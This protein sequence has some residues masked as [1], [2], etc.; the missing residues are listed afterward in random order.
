MGARREADSR[1]AGN[2]R[3]SAA[4]TRRRGS[5]KTGRGDEAFAERLETILGEITG[6]LEG[7]DPEQARDFARA[8]LKAKRIYVAGVGRSGLVSA[9]FAMRLVHLGLVAHVVGEVTA[10]GLG[11]GDLLVISSGSGRTRTVLAQ[12]NAAKTRGARV[13]VVTADARSPVAR[14]ADVLVVV[15]CAPFGKPTRG[16]S[17]ARERSVQ[18]GGTLF[19]Q[20]LLVFYDGLV[21]DLADRLDWS[22]KMLKLRHANLE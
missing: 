7:I 9:C 15:P 10:P 1:R 17:R 18:P 21:L 14:A 16:E 13:A 20:S 5:A 11:R 12:A 22:P 6:T 4:R 8:V 19:E 2:P 3:G